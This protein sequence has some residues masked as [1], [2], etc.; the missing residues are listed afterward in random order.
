MQARMFLIQGLSSWNLN[1][2][3]T[4]GAVTLFAQQ[5]S[6]PTPTPEDTNFMNLPPVLSCFW[7]AFRWKLDNT[8]APK[9]KQLGDSSV[10]WIQGEHNSQA[11]FPPALRNLATT[12][13]CQKTKAVSSHS[14][15]ASSSIK[16]ESQYR[17]A[18]L[19]QIIDRN[20][21]STMATSRSQQ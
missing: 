14:V 11:I 13:A 17:Q 15:E 20:I 6:G 10:W 4:V 3:Y 12:S 7:W 5:A 2:Y 18:T 21:L 1:F 19:G 16:F 8:H 9:H